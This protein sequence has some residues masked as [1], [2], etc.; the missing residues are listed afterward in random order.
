LLKISIWQQFSSNH[1]GGFDIV[2]VFE[3]AEAAAQA[4]AQLGEI[5]RAIAHARDE[6]A[7]YEAS[8]TLVER[9]FSA[10]YG[11]EW[12]SYSIDWI[13]MASDN[14]PLNLTRLD[15]YLFISNLEIDNTQ[16]DSVPVGALIE[17]L[18]GKALIGE[19]VGMYS[20]DVIAFSIT[21]TAPILRRHGL[22][23]KRSN[24]IWRLRARGNCL[25]LH[26]G[27]LLS[28]QIAPIRLL[29]MGT[30][31]VKVPCFASGI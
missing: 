15:Q 11:I 20:G 13:K 17:R 22:F 2:G 16:L 30:L 25:S 10:E 4:A 23:M 5:L 6:Y 31:P 1:S 27:R 21:C 24:R 8:P 14:T 12:S 3:S 19:E 28:P 26:L 9:M 29:I 18:G 7:H